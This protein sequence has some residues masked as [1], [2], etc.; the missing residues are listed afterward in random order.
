MKKVYSEEFEI[1]KKKYQ[2]SFRWTFIFAIIIAIFCFTL[3]FFMADFFIKQT[4]VIAENIANNIAEMS[5]EKTSRLSN[6]Q[7]FLVIFWNNLKIGIIAILFGLIPFYRLP[8]LFA[9]L[10]FVIVGVVFGGLYAM[11]HN[12]I[13]AFAYSFLPH[14]LI[15]LT[16]LIY[17]TAIGNFLN[18]NILTKVYFHKK[19]D[20]EPIGK[21][22]KQSLRSYIIVVMPLL[23]IAAF[24]EGF[25]TSRLSEFFL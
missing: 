17:C 5:G 18:R 20:S 13:G 7:T 22:L 12:V 2:K 10:Q 1:Y 23:F 24:V 14:A 16:A 9:I 3:S 25:I 15:E 19:K 11:G 4:K 6:I 21:L 8:S